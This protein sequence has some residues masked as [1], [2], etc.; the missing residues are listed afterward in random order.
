MSCGTT[1]VTT[2][3]DRKPR[4]FLPLLQQIMTLLLRTVVPEKRG[5]FERHFREVATIED[6]ERPD[7]ACIGKTLLNRISWAYPWEY[8]FQ[9]QHVGKMFQESGT[10]SSSLTISTSWTLSLTGVPIRMG[11]RSG[12]TTVHLLPPWRWRRRIVSGWFDRTN[13]RTTLTRQ[14]TNSGQW[15]CSSLSVVFFTVQGNGV[16]S[17]LVCQNHLSHLI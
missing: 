2:L 12:T 15:S 9:L 3:P 8:P 17:V 13:L 6:E 7:F 11:I 4:K 10:E 16:K 14:I 5:E 1:V